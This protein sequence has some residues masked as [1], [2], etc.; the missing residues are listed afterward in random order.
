MQQNSATGK[1][2]LSRPILQVKAVC[3]FMCACVSVFL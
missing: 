2:S 1:R 3:E